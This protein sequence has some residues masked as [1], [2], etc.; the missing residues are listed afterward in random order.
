MTWQLWC[1]HTTMPI[2]E[3]RASCDYDLTKITQDQAE[4]IAAELAAPIGHSTPHGSPGSPTPI[5]SMEAHP[6]VGTQPG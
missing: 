1:A 4:T 3:T 2:E 5:R 6:F